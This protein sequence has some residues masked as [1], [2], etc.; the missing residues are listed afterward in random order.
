VIGVVGN[1][2]NEGLS[3]ESGT[4][5]YFPASRATRQKLNLFIR[6][7]ND[8]ASVAAQIRQAIHGF[9]PD[10]AINDMAPLQ[11]VVHDTVAQPR[12]L[13]V[14][15]SVFGST[16]LLLA[17]VGVFGVISYNVRQRTREIGIRIALGADR[18][19]VM[20]MVLRKALTL[21]VIA[22]GTGVALALLSARLLARILFSVAP[23]D[24]LVLVSAVALLCAVAVSAALIPAGAAAR[25][26]PMV[27]LRCE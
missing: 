23:A 20:F 5:V 3:Q 18:R 2:R 11:Q 22:T 15:L 1:V 19:D 27:A 17:S 10:Q 25:V 26:D 21:I 7:K 24:P 8:P 12:F 9:E 4:A 16:A 13:S 14:V 6:T